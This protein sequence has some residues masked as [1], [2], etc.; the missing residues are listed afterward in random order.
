M[1]SEIVKGVGVD[2]AADW[3]PHNV[4][5]GQVWEDLDPRHAKEG[6]PR[7]V[8]VVSVGHTHAV[9]K[10]TVSGVRVTILLERF[11]GGKRTGYK[12]CE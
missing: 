10:N 8:E 1:A 3:N 12:L 6:V 9:V 2:E 7:M 11:R 4:T 5:E